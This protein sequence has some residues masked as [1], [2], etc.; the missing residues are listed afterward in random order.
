MKKYQIIYADPPY[1]IKWARSKNKELP[2][3]E[4]DYPTIP[5]SEICN[6]PIREISAED[7][8]LFL[9][10]TNEF[11]PEALGIIRSWKFRYDKL[12]TWCKNNGMGAHPRNAT[13]HIIIAKRG[14][15]KPK[16]GAHDKAILNW[17]QLPVRQKHS[18]KPPEIRTIIESLYDGNRIEL[19]ARQKVDGWTCLGLEISGKTIQ[20]ELANLITL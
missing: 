8:V 2:L 9:W 16:R 1:P 6:L 4:L 14:N 20:E 7:S 17:V 11:L 12:F 13:E 3:R 18:E 5:I 10:T 15:L 19:F